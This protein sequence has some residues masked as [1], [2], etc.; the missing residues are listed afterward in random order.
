MNKQPQITEK[1]RQKFIDVFCELYSQ[2]PVEKISIQEIASRSGYNRSTFYQ[3]FTDIYE[4]LDTVENNLLHD[5]KAELAGN[6]L[7]MHSVQDA[8]SCLDRKE[9]LLALHALLGDY[10]S[11]RFLARLKRDIPME[12]FL[13]LPQNHSLT[14]YFIEFYLTSTLSLFRLWLQQEKDIPPEEFIKLAEN[15]YSR[16]VSAYSDEGF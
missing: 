13:N 2:K 14:P 16:G 8:L 5:I 1:T 10:G 9:H 7:S 11:P 12:Q 6:E 3:Y 15:L 4:L